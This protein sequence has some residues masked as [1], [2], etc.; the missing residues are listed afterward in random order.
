LVNVDVTVLRGQQPPS[1]YDEVTDADSQQQ[2]AERRHRE[3]SV[4]RQVTLPQQV[5]EDDERA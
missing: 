4:R 3:E 5:V 1:E 2:D